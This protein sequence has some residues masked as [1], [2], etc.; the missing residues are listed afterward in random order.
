MH[1]VFTGKQSKTNANRE[2]TSPYTAPA[3]LGHLVTT[4]LAKSLA[5]VPGA[6]SAGRWGRRRRRTLNPQR[7]QS[8]QGGRRPT[9]HGRQ[10][11]PGS[12]TRVRDGR[13]LRV[14]GTGSLWAEPWALGDLSRSVPPS[15]PPHS[16]CLRL[17]GIHSLLKAKV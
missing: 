1:S 4:S 17:P 14:E 9:L 15:A 11:P 5:G 8:R 6:A 12:A 16:P 3:R 10:A 13:R 7:A 2:P